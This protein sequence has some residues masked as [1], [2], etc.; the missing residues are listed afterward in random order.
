MRTSCP[1]S[2]HLSLEH[3]RPRS[4]CGWLAVME[5]I[6]ANAENR[7]AALVRALAESVIGLDMDGTLSPIVEDPTR[8]RIHPDASAVLV[9]LAEVAKAIA[10]IT[11]RPA[12]QALALG[13]LDAVGDAIGEHGKELH[14]FGQYGNE[15]WSSTSRRIISP[16]PPRGLGKDR[17]ST[18]LNSSH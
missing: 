3:P 11:G 12:R 18:R 9:D 5:F 1:R 7:Y 8:A 2:G 6:S 15:R 17:K 16:R 10:I 13:G 4:R 14:V